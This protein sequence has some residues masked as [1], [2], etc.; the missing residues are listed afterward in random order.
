MNES[1]TEK[2]VIIYT[3]HPLPSQSFDPAMTKRFVSI[4]L[5]LGGED[6]LPNCW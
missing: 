2:E 3:L 4:A 5:M 6:G 1:Q